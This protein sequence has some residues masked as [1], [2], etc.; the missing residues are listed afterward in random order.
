MA[1]PT[2]DDPRFDNPVRAALSGAHARFA[3][4]SGRV[5][6]YAPDVA[7]FLALP[8]DASQ[9]DWPD[10]VELVGPGGIAA[11][12]DA[13]VPIVEPLRLI[14]TF[15]LVQMIGERA[16]G[17]ADDEAVT[18][19]PDDVPEMIELVTLTEP[20]PF[21]QRT[22]ELGRY[23]G[24]RRGGELVAMAGERMRFDG[25]TEISAVCTTP[26]SRGEGLA[27]RLVSALAAGIHD[28]SEQVFLHVLTSNTTAIRLYEEL[29]FVTGRRAELCV[30]ARPG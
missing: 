25:W 20:G 5:L 18:L 14:Q 10:V 12:M 7:P 26:A 1:P 11:F 16:Q 4:S 9:D 28:R 8:L 13:G 21:L 2:P 29:G 19:G 15:E 3:L 30:V 24:I 22:I 6:R 17:A 23:I 27:T